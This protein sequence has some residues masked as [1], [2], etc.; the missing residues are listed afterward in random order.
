MCGV[1]LIRIGYLLRRTPSGMLL[2]KLSSKR[3]PS[4]GSKVVDPGGKIVGKVADIIGN[5]NSPYLI[6]KPISKESKPK[7]FVELFIKPTFRRGKG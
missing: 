2:V 7:E 5:V 3:I 4:L 6:V 1:P